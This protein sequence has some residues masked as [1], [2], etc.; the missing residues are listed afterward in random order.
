MS[1]DT[2]AT[3]PTTPKKRRSLAHHDPDPDDAFEE[4]ESFLSELGDEGAMAGLAAPA[5]N[6]APAADVG[7]IDFDEHSM[8]LDDLE[9]ELGLSPQKSPADGSGKSKNTPDDDVRSVTSL[10]SLGSL[11]SL[12]D[13]EARIGP[14]VNRLAATMQNVHAKHT[15][16]VRSASSTN[17]TGEGGG[18]AGGEGGGLTQEG[19]HSSR[20]AAV[21]GVGS[22]DVGRLH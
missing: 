13:D 22:S 11:A 9:Q 20:I 8:W 14:E 18:A 15:D 4:M 6:E 1:A 12:A 17:S 19:D 7:T 3:P 10:A 21:A 2:K 16:A 5:A